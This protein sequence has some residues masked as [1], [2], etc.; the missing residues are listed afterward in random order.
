MLAFSTLP[1]PA[2]RDGGSVEEEAQFL[3]E[4][5]LSGCDLAGS[6]S[7]EAGVLA[8]LK[9]GEPVVIHIFTSGQLFTRECRKK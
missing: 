4:A 9:L 5:V 8:S 2:M 1:L 6:S 3:F 7:R